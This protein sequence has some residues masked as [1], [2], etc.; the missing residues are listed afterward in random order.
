MF[1]TFTAPDDCLHLV[2]EIE[3]KKWVSRIYHTRQC[4]GF[5]ILLT[6]DIT[7]LSAVIDYFALR[8]ISTILSPILQ[9]FYLYKMTYKQAWVNYNGM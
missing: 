7:N 1:I 8:S 6:N 2:W 3:I 5:I 4:L 9:S